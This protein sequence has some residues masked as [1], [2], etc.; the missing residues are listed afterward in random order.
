MPGAPTQPSVVVYRR[1]RDREAALVH[2]HDRRE[3]GRRQASRCGGPFGPSAVQCG[4]FP[5]PLLA[6]RPSPTPHSPVEQQLRE[7]AT[8]GYRTPMSLFGAGLP[9]ILK[10]VAFAML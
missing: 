4:A 3:A 8:L 5:L 10:V 9:A 2:G 6:W 1:V 7:A